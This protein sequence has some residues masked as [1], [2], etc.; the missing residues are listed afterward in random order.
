M[1]NKCPGP[2]NSLNELLKYSPQNILE[3]YTDIFILILKCRVVPQ[4]WCMGYIRPIFKIKVTQKTRI[5][6]VEL[7]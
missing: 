3:L 7:Q 4:Q 2:D 1:S 6:I 5:I